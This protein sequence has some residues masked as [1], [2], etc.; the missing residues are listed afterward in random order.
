MQ[1]RQ[2]G[3]EGGW[4]WSNWT[5]VGGDLVL[6]LPHTSY[7]M[8]L[9]WPKSSEAV[10]SSLGSLGLFGLNVRI[11]S[12]DGCCVENVTVLVTEAAPGPI[13][14]PW[15]SWH[16]NAL[17][18]TL[19]CLNIWNRLSCIQTDSSEWCWTSNHGKVL[20]VR[21][22]HHSWGHSTSWRI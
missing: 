6:F 21:G 22:Q 8:L 14:Q 19:D 20:I 2:K 10:S 16:S 17:S 12:Y 13:F 7:G 4:N 15:A 5:A 9:Q 3:A 11:H 18:V 1:T